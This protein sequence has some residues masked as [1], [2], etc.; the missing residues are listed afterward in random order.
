MIRHH[1]FKYL[2]T[3]LLVS[4]F[5][6]SPAVAQRGIVPVPVI[7]KAGNQV[8]LYRGS[9]ALIIGVSDYTDGWPDLPE[10][11][12]DLIAVGNVLE[13]IG[14]QVYKSLNPKRN[15]LE[16]VINSF[17]STH[18]YEKDS[19]LIIYFAGHGHTITPV[20]RQMNVDQSCKFLRDTYLPEG[21]FL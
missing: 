19:R 21:V 20:C 13:Q 16:G 14:F 10:V 2:I 8:G 9:Y 11:K 7:D 6:I 18:G 15:E 4:A 1:T 17:I 12:E 3:F 5:T